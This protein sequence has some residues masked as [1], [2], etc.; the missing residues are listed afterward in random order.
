MNAADPET[1]ETQWDVTATTNRLMST[2]KEVINRNPNVKE[3]VDLWCNKRNKKIETTEQLLKCYYASI[4][5]VRFPT[6]VCYAQIDKQLYKLHDKI[7]N[8]CELA[9]E[10]K[11]NVHMLFNGDQLQ[12]YLQA[13]FD[14]F[15]QNLEMP[16]NFVNEALRNN[17]IPED[18]SENILILALA[19]KDRGRLDGLTLD[20]PKIFKELSY[21]V[22]SCIVLESVRQ[23][24]KGQ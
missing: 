16:F 7:R 23:D 3:F 18:F 14:H 4:S 20:G 12:I 21:M 13:A 24:R 2:I 1:E 19:V 6:K 8:C 15:A 9:Y 22:A 17:P 10:T 11:S 5:V